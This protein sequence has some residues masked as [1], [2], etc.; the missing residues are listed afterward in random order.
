MKKL[1]HIVAVCCAALS[2]AAFQINSNIEYYFGT[3]PGEALS[4]STDGKFIMVA[5]PASADGVTFNSTVPQLRHHAEDDDPFGL[6][7]T[8]ALPGEVTEVGLPPHGQFGLA[9]VRSDAAFNGN[10]LV[11]IR[12]NGVLQEISIPASPDGMK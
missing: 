4:V 9:V 6:R 11:A 7:R 1:K 12:G 5:S 8:L 3:G 10:L 2:T